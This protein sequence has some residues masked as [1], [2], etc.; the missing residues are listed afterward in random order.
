MG[1]NQGSKDS[2]AVGQH[3]SPISL[4]YAY[5]HEDEAL[6]GEL[7]KHLRLLQHQGLISTWH[8]RHIAPGADW[9]KA[10]TIA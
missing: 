7:E 10:L 1:N 8:D 6:R 9:V 2:T 3:L 5:A 4:F